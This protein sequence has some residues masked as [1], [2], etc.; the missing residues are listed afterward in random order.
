MPPDEEVPVSIALDPDQVALADAVGSFLAHHAPTDRTRE[1]LD[2]LSGGAVPEVWPAFLAQGFATVH[3]P[4]PHGGGTFLDL[5][6]ILEEAGRGLLPGPALAAAVTSAVLLKA[7]APQEL[8][9][10]FADGAVG[11]TATTTAGL[12]AVPTPTGYTVSGTSAPI[13]GAPGAGVIVVGA[14][15]GHGDDVWFVVDT[16]GGAPIKVEAATA[17]DLTRA[18][19]RLT[20]DGYD[21]P[22][23]SV[24]AATTGVVRA[25]SAALFAAEAVGVVGWLVKATNDYAKIR[26]QFGRTIG[27]FQAI[28]HKLARMFIQ[29]QIMAATAWDAARALG[30]DDEQ[31][32]L[33]AAAAAIS[34]LPVAAELG[35]EAITLF[36][37]IGYT[38]EHDAHLY[39]RRAITLNALIGP[40]GGWRRDLGQRSRT[41]R[42]NFDVELIGEDPD[43]RARIAET[44]AEAD[45]LEGQQQRDFLQEQGLVLPHYPPPYG[46]GASAVEQI[47]IAQEYAKS[48]VSQPRIVIGEWALPT[49]LAHGTDE[50]KEAFVGPTLRGE[51]T[52]CQLFSEPGAGSDL[53]SLSTK[54]ERVE[55]GWRLTGQ[56]IWTSM[57]QNAH[58]GICLARTDSS[59]PKHQ[60]ITYFLVDMHSDGLEVRPLREANGQYLF[61]EVFFDEVFVPDD[62][63]VGEVNGGWRLARTT[64]SNERVSIG[65]MLGFR[66]PMY[67]YA[68]RDDLV[69]TREEV[70]DDLGALTAE[71]Y[72]LAAMRLR[73]LMRRLSGLQPG[74]EGSAL[75]VAA[76]W[77]HVAVTSTAMRWFGPLAA[78]G[79]APGGM[80]THQY[81]SSP[82]VLL[83]GGT[84]EIQLNVIAERILGLPRD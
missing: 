34:C 53:A 14:A 76:G 7:G 49:I 57:A 65:G 22:A 43:F 55:G 30:E 67:D 19:G 41:S 81:L 40:V 64:L 33:A 31:V 58:W 13:L 23:E 59:L 66:L 61:N 51:I 72:A 26:E 68:D 39:W 17:V 78:V 46:L 71:S 48:P 16:E 27:S 28:K 32:Q 8:I 5:A 69:V 24:V 10:R 52:W 1:Q 3:L 9:A 60:G 6:V 45:Q 70:N 47:V 15:T 4:E 54:A 20:F 83:G 79:D 36:G 56:K 25:V 44:L 62:R 29:L 80:S 73:D 84:L 38:W 11:A 2:A 50:Q 12:T 77:Q 35:L 63:V 82:P 74:V 75:K 42:R 18:V 37:G 21:V